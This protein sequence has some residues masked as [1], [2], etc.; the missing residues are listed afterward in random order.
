[1]TE[2]TGQA[3]P[4]AAAET[5]HA[6]D[7]TTAQAAP[8]ASPAETTARGDH[9]TAAPAAFR[10]PLKSTNRPQDRR[11]RDTIAC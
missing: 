7:P 1:M 5:G 6:A 4:Q 2:T 9:Y 3:N 8:Q 10:N 11:A